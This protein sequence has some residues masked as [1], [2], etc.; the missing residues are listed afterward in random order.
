MLDAAT[1]CQF[2]HTSATKEDVRT[3]AI[4]NLGPAGLGKL[5]PQD[6]TFGALLAREHLGTRDG[7]KALGLPD[8]LFSMLIR[9]TLKPL[10]VGAM[11]DAELG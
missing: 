4:P 3:F 6:Q 2:G 1:T 5:S 7:A 8:R 9:R 11:R 10:K